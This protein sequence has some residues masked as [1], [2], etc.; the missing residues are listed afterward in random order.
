[1]D[2]LAAVYRHVKET[3][4]PPILDRTL[5]ITGSKKWGEEGALLFAVRVD[6]LVM[7]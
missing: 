4:L 2:E 5:P 7:F 3:H 1:M 6:R